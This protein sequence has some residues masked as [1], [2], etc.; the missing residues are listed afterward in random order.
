MSK[1]VLVFKCG[2][3]GATPAH[4]FSLAFLNSRSFSLE[5]LC[6]NTISITPP[7][8]FKGIKLGCDSEDIEKAL[9]QINN[10]L[11][12]PSQS[13]NWLIYSTQWSYL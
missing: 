6:T 7:T 1:S 12:F 2:H 11:P 10:S 9:V 4:K 3:F 5:H 8:I 13:Y